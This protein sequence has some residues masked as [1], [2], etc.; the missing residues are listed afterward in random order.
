[1]IQLMSLFCLLMKKTGFESRY[2]HLFFTVDSVNSY[3]FFIQ[4]YY[5]FEYIIQPITV[6]E[7]L[8]YA[9]GCVI[10]IQ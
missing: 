1:M 6:K 4:R 10:M 9:T 8:D 5:L 7:H 2:N 3:G